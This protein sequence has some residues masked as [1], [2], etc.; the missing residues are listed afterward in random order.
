MRQDGRDRPASDLASRHSILLRVKPRRREI[1][2]SAEREFPIAAERPRPSGERVE[3]LVDACTQWM[4][5]AF[6]F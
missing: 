5:S 3:I 2:R 4:H 6:T 1:L